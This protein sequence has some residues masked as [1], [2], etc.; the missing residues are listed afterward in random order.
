M[1]LIYFLRTNYVRK[2]PQVILAV[3]RYWNIVIKKMKSPGL[4]I[5]EL[6]GF[7]T[8]GIALKKALNI[9]ILQFIHPHHMHDNPVF[10]DNIQRSDKIMHVG[11]KQEIWLVRL[12]EP[13]WRGC[14]FLRALAMYKA[15]RACIL[16]GM[17]V[18]CTPQWGFYTLNSVSSR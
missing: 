4:D 2:Y 1:V 5:M 14:Q 15:L 13:L 3:T 18:I 12:Q 17:D 7:V 9:S 8:K 11:G 10:C 16:K 6:D